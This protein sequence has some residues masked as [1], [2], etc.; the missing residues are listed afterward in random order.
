MR[1]SEQVSK[2][3]VCDDIVRVGHVLSTAGLSPGTTG[4][5]SAVHG[6]TMICTPTGA[7]LSALDPAELSVVTLAGE[8][9]GGIRP[10]KESFMHVAMYRAAPSIQ[11]VIHLHSSYATAVA[12][13]WDV[14]HDDA[15]P[16]ITP[17]LT[18]RAGNV[19]VIPYFPPGDKRIAEPIGAR[20]AQGSRA[21]LLANH[22]SLVGAGSLGDAAAISQ[23][24]EEAAKLYFITKGHTVRSLT[25]AQRAELVGARYNTSAP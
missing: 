8:H 16:P 7:D 22:G 19:C 20:A 23:E 2:R 14:D 5:I 21:M 24:L 13:L 18:M 4:N 25:M 12:C 1:E 15:I 10:T 11:A 6:S 3:S 9:V 17:Y